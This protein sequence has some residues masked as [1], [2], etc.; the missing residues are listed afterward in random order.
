ML[1]D[2]GSDWLKLELWSWLMP[3]LQKNIFDFIPFFELDYAHALQ[4][5]FKNKDILGVNNITITY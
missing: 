4:D 1:N 5:V 3:I 2:A